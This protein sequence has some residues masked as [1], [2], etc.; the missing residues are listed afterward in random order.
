MKSSDDILV[1][2][3]VVGDEA[4]IASVHIHAWQ[5]SYRGQIPENLL[6]ALPLS[7]AKRLRWWASVLLGETKTHVFVAESPAHGIVGFCAVEPARDS[8]YA[9]GS[10][11]C[12]QQPAD[13]EDGDHQQ[14]K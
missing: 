10:P 4:S 13:C 1:R 12:R 6:A 14:R 11:G 2:P 8:A 7:F 9:G 3:A 5:Q